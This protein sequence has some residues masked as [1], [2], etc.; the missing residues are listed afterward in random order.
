MKYL[1]NIECVHTHIYIYVYA[2]VYTYI[3]IHIRLMYMIQYDIQWYP[4]FS[5]IY[6]YSIN[7][8]YIYILSLLRNMEL[9]LRAKPLKTLM[10]NSPS[11]SGLHLV[12]SSSTSTTKLGVLSLVYVKRLKEIEF[13]WLIRS[14]S[15]PKP[16]FITGIVKVATNIR[17]KPPQ[18][19]NWDRI[20][21]QRFGAAFL[22][23][24][25]MSLFGGV[26]LSV[27]LVQ[28]WERGTLKC[29]AIS[30]VIVQHYFNVCDTLPAFRLEWWWSGQKPWGPWK[31]SK[32][33]GGS[34]HFV[35]FYD[36]YSVLSHAGWSQGS[37]T[38]L[39]RDDTACPSSA[40]ARKASW[41]KHQPVRNPR[42]PGQQ[43][44]GAL[45]F[46]LLCSTHVL[47]KPLNPVRQ[48]PVQE[49]KEQPRKQAALHRAPHEKYI[50]W[51][52]GSFETQYYHT[53]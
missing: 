29:V 8:S 43:L 11:R 7:I 4:Y 37:V 10:S 30:Y 2:R 5:C 17:N 1:I 40:S 51:L 31:A 46:R 18:L 3:Y 53:S 33:H 16:K 49:P 34:M 38:P 50:L 39:P 52:V 42:L 44:T 20:G 12:A 22:K 9:Q 14:V 26:H 28:P 35:W 45:G 24:G 19:Y 36:L 47:L 27:Q 23:H 21:Y 32:F 25:N 41:I 15:R 13:T 48:Y 6:I